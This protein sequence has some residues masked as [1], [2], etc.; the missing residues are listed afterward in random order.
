[1]QLQPRLS[2][3]ESRL[4]AI[5]L[6]DGE[7]LPEYPL[8]TGETAISI[9]REACAKHPHQWLGVWAWPDGMVGMIPVP[10][11]GERVQDV[12][13]QMYEIVRTA[14]ERQVLMQFPPAGEA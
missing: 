14:T 11:E 2:T 7:P 13:A 12:L 1:M 8:W 6:R 10:P 5:E 4:L 9:F 3:A